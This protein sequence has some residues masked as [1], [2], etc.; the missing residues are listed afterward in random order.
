MGG[1]IHRSGIAGSYDNSIFEFLRTVMLFSIGTIPFYIPFRAQGSNFSTSSST[2]VIF[3]FI[4]DT[5]YPNGVR[6]CHTAILTC[7]YLMISDDHLFMCLLA[8]CLSS[9]KKYLFK[10][11]SHFLIQLLIL[12]FLSFGGSLCILNIKYYFC[13]YYALFVI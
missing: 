5:S 7:I 8:C 11:F 10:S 12:L 9:L 1:Y 13:C 6:W 4:F 3:C 2:L